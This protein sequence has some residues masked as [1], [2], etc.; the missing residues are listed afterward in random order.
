MI[1]QYC[2]KKFNDDHI[3]TLGLD[4]AQKK[5]TAKDGKE[6]N[7]KIWDTAGQERFKT[8]TYGFYRRA[9][10]VIIAYDTT[11]KHTFDNVKSWIDSINKHTGKEIPRILV[12][13][14]I[15]LTENRTVSVE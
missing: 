13:N 5:F 2:Q 6:Y 10:G 3:T 4:F 9:D 14:K 15:D 11:E 7:I 12:S 8:M 1:T